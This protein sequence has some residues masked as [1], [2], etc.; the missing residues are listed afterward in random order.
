M[1]IFVT[2][3]TGGIGSPLVRE[4]IEAGHQVVGLARSDKSAAALTA[5]GA[6]V[7]R[8]SIEDLDSLR[9]GAADADGVIHLA[10]IHDY[11]QYDGAVIADLHAVE[12]MG[13]VLVGSGSTFGY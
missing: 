6:E 10:F 11:S 9:K 8:G 12:A 5:A 4:L 13:D 1:R 3:A 2:G 7:H